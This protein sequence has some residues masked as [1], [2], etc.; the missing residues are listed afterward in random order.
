MHCIIIVCCWFLWIAREKGKLSSRICWEHP[1]GFSPIMSL[2]SRFLPNQIPPP[3]VSP[4]AGT[5]SPH[6]VSQNCCTKLPPAIMNRIPEARREARI[7]QH[8]DPS[9]LFQTEWPN[10]V[11]TTSPIAG[12]QLPG[13]PLLQTIQSSAGSAKQ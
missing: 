11:M 2:Y 13:Q 9:N 8:Q 4:S 5:R 6:D 3:T 1:R 7:E 10:F 12:T